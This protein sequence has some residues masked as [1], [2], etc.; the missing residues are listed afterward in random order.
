MRSRAPRPRAGL[1]AFVLLLLAAAPAAADGLATKAHAVLRTYCYRCHGQGGT[2]KGGMNFILDRDRLLARKK[3]VPGKAAESPLFER[4]RDGEMPPET[5]KVRPRPDEVAVL[6][7]WIDAGAPAFAPTLPA[8]PFLSEADVSR[9]V[10]TDLRNAEPRRRRFLRYF[11]FAHLAG[12]GVSPADLQT[13]RQALAKLVNSLSWHPRIALPRPIDPDG[14]ILRVD[15]RELQW[16]AAAWTHIL[17][18][19]PY[20]VLHPT[21]TPEA[22]DFKALTGTELPWVKGDWFV[23]TASRPPLYRDLLQLPVSD[24]ELERQLR[25]DVLQ[26]IEDETAVRSGFNGSGVAKNN[27]LLE[28]HDAAFG[29]YW[30]SYD[31]SDNTDR[32]NLFEHPLGPTPG[33]NSFQHA[34]GEIIFSLPNGLHAYLLVDGVGRRVDRAPIEIVS[35]PKRP[36]R[37]VE[38]GVSCFGCH[39]RGLIHKADQVRAHVEKNPTAFAPEDVAVIRNLYPSEAKFKALLDEDA[40][41]YAKAAARTGVRVEDPE[42]ISA[43]TLRYEGELDLA[44]AAAELGLKPEDL[45]QRLAKSPALNRVLGP[46]SVRGGTVQRQV[47][48]TA[49]F[50]LVRELRLTDDPHVVATPETTP[51]AVVGLRPFAGHTGH[52]LCIA[53]SPDGRQALSGGEDNSVRLWDVAT[54]RELRCFEGH[55]GEVLSVAFSPDGRRAVSGSYDRTMRLWDVASGRELRRFEGHTERVSG[56][57]FSSDGRRALSGSWDQTLGLWDVASGRLLHRLAGHTGYVSS[58]AFAPDGR[59]ALSGSY[60]H[61]VRLWDLQTGRTLATL[62]GHT[63]EV[64]AVTFSPD[65]RRAA[66][67]GNDQTVRVWDMPSGRLLATLTGH[68]RAVIRVAFTAD[69]RQ[70][71]SAGSQYQGGDPAVRVWDVAGGK[72]VR[73]F[74]GKSDTVW[75]MAFSADGRRAL[76]GSADR[77]LRLW[78]LSK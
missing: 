40:D 67:G 23:A 35:D 51:A 7:Q 2:A 26:D 72:R 28:R 6:R 70:V 32:Q 60:D 47:F 9:L 25:V 38:T 53:F 68:N 14:T 52:V 22:K 74:G 59:S 65:G 43:L 49:L 29:A 21:T 66:S 8:R 15:L 69:G 34:G 50:D 19:Y 33:Q 31:F 44:T 18:F 17:E 56:V 37:F 76:S 63:R 75:S 5:V 71:L 3:I 36:D 24:R 46:L 61:S 73:S 58:V 54:G 4:I 20:T 1:P 77:T 13:A 41:R 12:A 42:P 10:R 30:R 78:D 11:S 57:A 64:Y 48:L 45:S 16:N 27:R 62:D 39:V 55:T